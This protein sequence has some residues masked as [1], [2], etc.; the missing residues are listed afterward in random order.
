MPALGSYYGSRQL[1]ADQRVVACQACVLVEPAGSCL[2]AAS[3]VEPAGGVAGW[4]WLAEGVGEQP[5]DFV[6]GERDQAGLAAIQAQA[7]HRS[8]L[9]PHARF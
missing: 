3:P 5:L 1:L 4:V 7:Y 2:V 9:D 6:D 8:P